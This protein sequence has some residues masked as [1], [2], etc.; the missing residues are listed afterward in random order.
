MTRIAQG[1]STCRTRSGRERRCSQTAATPSPMLSS[2]SRLRTLDDLRSDAAV[3]TSLRL[4]TQSDTSARSDADSLTFAHR[5]ENGSG[6]PWRLTF[7]RA[8][9]LAVRLEYTGICIA[10]DAVPRAVRFGARAREEVHVGRHVD[11]QHLDVD[12]APHAADDQLVAL[13]A[14]VDAVPV[15]DVRAI[16]RDVRDVIARQI[17]ER[18]IHHAGM[19]CVRSVH[20]SRCSS[21]ARPIAACTLGNRSV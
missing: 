19:R 18:P 10:C 13:R 14:A 21:A 16:R 12:A 9:L 3:G 7:A 11:V 20:S 15:V 8:G 4:S 5:F 2:Q 17:A 1:V 6:P